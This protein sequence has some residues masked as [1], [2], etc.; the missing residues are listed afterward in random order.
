MEWL[1]AIGILLGTFLG[2]SIQ[3]E[4]TAS[5]EVWPLLILVPWLVWGLLVAR[6]NKL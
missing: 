5:G 3:P 1:P 6:S 2:K 4:I